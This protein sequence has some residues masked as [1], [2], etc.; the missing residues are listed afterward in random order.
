MR[1]LMVSPYPPIRDGIASYAVQEV[2]A[3][4]RRGPR[5]RGA[6]AVALGRAPPPRV[7]RTAWPARAGQARAP[8]RPRDHPVPPRHLLS[9]AAR[10]TRSSARDRG[11]GDRVRPQAQRRGPAPRDELRLGTRAGHLR[12][13]VALPVAAPGR[14]HACTPNTNSTLVADSIGL[15]LERVEVRDHGLHFVRARDHRP[16][17]KRARRLGIDESTFVFLA[18]GFV[19]PHK[20]FDRAVRAFD[21][22]GGSRLPA[23]R[24]RIRAR[25]RAGTSWTMRRRCVVSSTAT[26]RRAHA[27]GLRQRRDFRRLAGR[28]RRAAPAVPLHLVVRCA[29]S[30]PRCTAPTS[31]RPASAVSTSNSTPNVRLVDDDFE[32]ALAMREAAKVPVGRAASAKRGRLRRAARLTAPRSKPRSANGRRCSPI[33]A[34]GRRR[35]RPERSRFA[36]G[37]AAAPSPEAVVA[38]S[39]RVPREEGR[40]EAHRVADRPHRPSA[41]RGAPRGRRR[42][43]RGPRR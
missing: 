35:L 5:R 32:L 23:R 6:L 21:G 43:R 13:A 11:P 20:G 39:A 10:R 4:A 36:R 22:L 15:P 41:E 30:A 26:P 1:I 3:L 29:R 18:I 31:S 38:E 2:A 37:R 12:P 19:Q 40:A 33:R 17:T 28:R 27:R 9:A 25:R 34:R 16:A 42:T 8:L 7:A 24:R 14:D